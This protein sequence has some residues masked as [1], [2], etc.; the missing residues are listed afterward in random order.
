M[1]SVLLTV[2]AALASLA[3][4]VSAWGAHLPRVVWG[5][6]YAEQTLLD[7]SYGED[8]ALE[9]AQCQG[10]G[11]A[12]YAADGTP[13]YL[14]FS[15][16]LYYIDDDGSLASY[17]ASLRVVGNPDRFALSK[18]S[19]P[20]FAP[21]GATNTAWPTPAPNTGATAGAGHATGAQP[22]MRTSSLFVSVTP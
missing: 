12:K 19:D 17:S 4:V 11:R 22:P 20:A 2:G 5:E 15:C 9:D 1:K 18:V 10:R 21:P 6:Q 13:L 7:S 3:F 8:K 14:N 16:S